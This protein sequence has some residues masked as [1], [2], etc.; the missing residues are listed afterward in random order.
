MNRLLF[1]L[2]ICCGCIVALTSWLRHSPATRSAN[3]DL[4]RFLGDKPL[5]ITFSPVAAPI[6][7]SPREL[8]LLAEV[9]HSSPAG[10]SDQ[11]RRSRL[12]HSSRLSDLLGDKLEWPDRDSMG[13]PVKCRLPGRSLQESWRGL[14]VAETATGDRTEHRDQLLC[15]LAEEGIP[16]ECA[17]ESEEERGFKVADLLRTSLREFHLD[18]EELSWTSVAYALYLPPQTVWRNRYGET[19]SFDDLAGALM[20]RSLHSESCGGTHLLWSLTHVLLADRVSPILEHST[21]RELES[22]LTRRVAQAVDSQLPDGS[23]PWL[24]SVEGFAPRP[25]DLRFTPEGTAESRM[26]VTGHLLEWFHLLPT[27][28]KPPHA[29]IVAG[30]NWTAIQLDSASQAQISEHFCPF[31]H[32]IRA[33]ELSQLR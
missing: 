29:T 6:D 24:W 23:W 31:T 9:V 10:E 19:Y 16:L 21:R 28:L 7:V 17:V 14:E 3:D 33:L 18:Q 4:V 5:E 11:R 15:T 22:F 30:L 32:A 20:R 13:R 25:H 1:I 8:R 2:A 27:D 12:L 26:T